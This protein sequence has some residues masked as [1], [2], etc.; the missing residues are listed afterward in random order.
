MKRQ[1]S[2]TGALFS[3]LFL[4]IISGCGEQADQVQT[5]TDD[6][7][8]EQVVDLSIEVPLLRVGHCK[9]DHHSAVFVSALRG[10]RMNELYGIYLE[11][12]GE[13]YYALVE[14]GQKVVEIE[15]VQSQGAINVPNNMVAGLFEIGFGGVIP[16]AA[17][18][19][20]GSGVKIISPLHS[21][22]DMLVVSI[23]NDAVNDW[24]SFIEWVNT[25][26]EPLIIGFKSPKAVALL[27]FESALT[28]A[29]ISWSMQGNPE[30]DSKILLFNAQ[31]QPN[32]N[33]ALQNGTV[34][35]Y[36]SN[37]PA[38]ALAEHN[39]IGKCVVELSDLPP[40]D[41]RNHPCCA[42]AATETAIAEKSLEIAASLRLFAA[43]TDYI[44]NNPEDAAVVAAE[45]IGNPVEVE[46]ISMA[47]SRYSM[48]VSLDW[49]ENM[50]VILDNMRNLG[51]FTGPL[52]EK[53][54]EVNA[55]FLY[56]FS[57]MPENLR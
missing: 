6:T 37:N 22:G 1:I 54:D 11:P 4:I 36:V 53:D 30:P 46:E 25:S 43:A 57:L 33:P 34:D 35:A 51:A 50:V 26:E 45:W 14:N 23:D 41:F 38:C 21:R 55:C 2:V 8:Q 9:H 27:I 56:D 17:S 15:F 52:T 42:I 7:I 28:E 49:L 16:F 13:S 48:E 39:G 18:A 44:N 47:T 19:D 32:L 10:E 29:G 5:D 12:L 24:D 3:I 40:G 31:G 20:K